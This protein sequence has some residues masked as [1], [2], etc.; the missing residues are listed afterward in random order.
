VTIVAIHEILPFIVAIVAII[1]FGVVRV[2]K[3]IVNHR[4]RIALIEMGIHPD[5]PPLDEDVPQAGNGLA[6]PRQTG[7]TSK[8][9]P[10]PPPAPSIPARK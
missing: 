3:A 9:P 4:E 5:Y 10:S 7:L 6:P 2:V 8:A 1:V